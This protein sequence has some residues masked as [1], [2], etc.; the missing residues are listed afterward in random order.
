MADFSMLD[1]EFA[2]WG[3]TYV[4]KGGNPTTTP[5]QG[6]TATYSTDNPEIVKFQFTSPDGGTSVDLNP[7]GS[8]G[9]YI[10]SGKIGTATVTI[11]GGGTASAF[12]PESASVEIAGTEAGAFNM[13]FGTPKTEGTPG[14]PPAAARA[15]R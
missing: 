5:P 6:A 14:T 12:P 10:G 2:L 8:E 11:T 13:T 3:P 15:R 9:T 7:D 4:D 1:T